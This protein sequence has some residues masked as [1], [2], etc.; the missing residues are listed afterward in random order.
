MT[1]GDLKK[2]P[3]DIQDLITKGKKE[4]ALGKMELAKGTPVGIAQTPD[5]ALYGQ[6]AVPAR[7]YVPYKEDVAFSAKISDKYLGV[8]YGNL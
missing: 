5:G 1:I 4:W 6:V 2:L 8:F 3:L 7:N